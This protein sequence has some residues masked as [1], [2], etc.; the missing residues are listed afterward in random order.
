VAESLLCGCPLLDLA[1]EAGARPVDVQP[2]ITIS[3][4]EDCRL[5]G[6][7]DVVTRTNSY[8]VRTGD[9]ADDMISV[10]FTLRRYWG[11]RPKVALEEMIA[12]LAER[13]DTLCGEYVL[14]RI[15]RPLSAA[16]ASRS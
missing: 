11:D 7:I 1:E 3:L 8:Q 5:Q 4:S 6:R 12:E 16:I 13:A 9:Y 2:S 15:V 14:P 10:Y